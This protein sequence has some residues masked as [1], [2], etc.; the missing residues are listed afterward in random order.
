MIHTVEL[1]CDLNKKEFI[2]VK[3]TYGIENDR[4][5]DLTQYIKG[6]GINVTIKKEVFVSG[7]VWRVTMFVDFIKVLGKADITIQDKEI[8]ISIISEKLENLIFV[9]KRLYLKRIDYRFDKIVE[10]LVEREILFKLFN[11]NL[12]RKSYMNKINVFNKEHGRSN[13]KK[14]SVIYK[15]KSRRTNV[16]DKEEE[17][18][19]KEEN[20]MFY[21]K[22]VIR[23]EAQVRLKHINYKQIK[24]KVENTL[25]EY[26]TEEKYNYYMHKMIIE[27]LG[28]GDYYNCYHA[29][30]I[31]N[32]SS[33]KDKDKKEL[34]KFLKLASEKRSLTKVKEL[35]SDYKYNKIIKNLEQLKINRIIIPKGDRITHIENP[36]NYIL[37]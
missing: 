30:K 1:Y 6:D 9:K 4:Y 7:Q 2:R 22:D 3:S 28:K 19:A 25:E 34:V 36:I 24:Y 37:I 18:I 5:Y 15:N 13:K 31:I 35:Y 16:Y 8:I 33:L 23:F 29:S 20:I 12:D 10:N 17:R 11:K 21:E 14:T 27:T 26:F 32:S